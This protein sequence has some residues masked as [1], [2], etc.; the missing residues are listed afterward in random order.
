MVI[1]KMYTQQS[2]TQRN[3]I[4]NYLQEEEIVISIVLCKWVWESLKKNWWK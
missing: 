1:N 3:G 4:S 2:Y